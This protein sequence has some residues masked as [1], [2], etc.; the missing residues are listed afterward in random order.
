M[1]LP[2]DGYEAFARRTAS[3]EMEAGE[4]PNE[5]VFLLYFFMFT[6]EEFV[7]ALVGV[8]EVFEMV[9][10]REREE[11][12]RWAKRRKLGWWLG[13]GWFRDQKYEKRVGFWQR[14][15]TPKFCPKSCGFNDMFHNLTDNLIPTFP[16]TPSSSPFPPIDD[17]SMSSHHFS[18]ASDP[19]EPFA[20]RVKKLIWWVGWRL[21][22][23]DVKYGLKAGIGAAVLA[24]PAFI[25]SWRPTYQAY[26]GHWSIVSVRT[27]FQLYLVK[28][29]TQGLMFHT[30]YGRPIP[31]VWSDK[32]FD[33]TPSAWNDVWSCGSHHL[34]RVVSGRCDLCVVLSLLR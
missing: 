7:R 4:G 32:L 16:L 14:L 22:Q 30:V 31:F 12:E 26:K 10:L 21:R 11:E 15:S 24:A 34:L 17:P 20:R 3:E 19:S 13:G 6:M 9:E 2:F 1:T 27:R 25:D 18:A 5:E 23:A 28:I 33:D 29:R 8:V